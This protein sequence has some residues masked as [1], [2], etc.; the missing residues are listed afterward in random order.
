MKIA[1]LVKQTPQLSE[2]SWGDNGLEW[3][4]DVLAPPTLSTLNPSYLGEAIKGKI[5]LG[6]KESGIPLLGALQGRKS[7]IS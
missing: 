1:V 7:F 3:P 6:K 5:S 4:D 2:V